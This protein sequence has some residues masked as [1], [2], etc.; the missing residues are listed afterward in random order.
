MFALGEIRAIDYSY[1]C[2][3][4]DL[5]KKKTKQIIYLPK[6]VNP[7]MDIIYNRHHAESLQKSFD[8]FESK[9]ITDDMTKSVTVK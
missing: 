8:R 6:N 2:I 9:N 5:K 4:Q 1:K 7:C 3:T